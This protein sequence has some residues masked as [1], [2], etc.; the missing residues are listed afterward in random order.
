V[1]VDDCGCSVQ[2]DLKGGIAVLNLLDDKQGSL[3]LMPL[4]VLSL[5]SSVAFLLSFS[6][7]LASASLLSVVFLGLGWQHEG[8]V[9]HQ[10]IT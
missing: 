1:G 10:G 5:S 6:P 9:L 7:L 4:L 3:S 2:Y 8:A